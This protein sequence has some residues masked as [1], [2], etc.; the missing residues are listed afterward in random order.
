MPV[1]H[2]NLSDHQ[3]EPDPTGTE[4]PDLRTAR[5]E[6]VMFAGAYLRDEPGLVGGGEEFR[7]DVTD[8]AGAKLFSIVVRSVDF[9]AC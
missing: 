4:L 3:K 2:F 5:A 6:A 7:V 9:P 8:D 1:Y